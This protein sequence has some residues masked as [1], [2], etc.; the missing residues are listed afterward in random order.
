MS[1]RLDERIRELFTEVDAAAPGAPPMPVGKTQSVPLA[2]WMVPAAGVAVAALVIGVLNF[3]PASEG[4]D[5]TAVGGAAATTAQ[6]ATD[7]TQAYSET[8]SA[9]SETTEPTGQ[10]LPANVVADL[11]DACIAWTEEVTPVVAA[12]PETPDQYRAIFETVET[13]TLT[14]SAS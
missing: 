14:L 3:L 1:S 11:D 5:T 9:A 6:E 10:A 8:T 13:P 4:A 7:T 12:R 2:R